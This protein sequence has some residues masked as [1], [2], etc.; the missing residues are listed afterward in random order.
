M[1]TPW[2]WSLDVDTTELMF[3]TYEI[4]ERLTEERRSSWGRDR[5]KELCSTN[6]PF[7]HRCIIPDTKQRLPLVRVFDG[8]SCSPRLGA[9]DGPLWE[10]LL[11]NRVADDESGEIQGKNWPLIRRCR[12]SQ[13]RCQIDTAYCMFSRLLTG[14]DM[15]VSSDGHPERLVT[16]LDVASPPPPASQTCLVP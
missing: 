9:G 8:R 5:C 4:L 16:S 2:R 11:P 15:Y 1:A 6:W 13:S 7:H 10:A 12:S 14:V 3:Q